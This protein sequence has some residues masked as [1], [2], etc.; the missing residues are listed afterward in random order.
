MAGRQHNCQA[1]CQVSIL[2]QFRPEPLLGKQ[3]TAFIKHQHSAGSTVQAVPA[4][5]PV[6]LKQISSSMTL[7]N[8]IRRLK[9]QLILTPQYM[10]S[11]I[12]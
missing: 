3:T 7:L 5:P 2:R 12:R 9:S 4:R 11:R 8:C 1:Y 10:L 6:Y